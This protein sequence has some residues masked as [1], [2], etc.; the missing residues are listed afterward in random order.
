MTAQARSYSSGDGAKPKAPARYNKSVLHAGGF[1]DKAQAKLE[2]KKAYSYGFPAFYP[3][4]NDY[5]DIILKENA[6][7]AAIYMITNKVTKLKY[8][9]KSSNLQVRFVYFFSPG[10][11]EINKG[12][13]LISRYLL[14]FGFKNFSLT[15]L[16]Y[17]PIDDLQRR[18]QYFINIFKPLLNIRK[19]ISGGVAAHT[20][21]QSPASINLVAPKIWKKKSSPVGFHQPAEYSPTKSAESNA[22]SINQDGAAIINRLHYYNPDLAEFKKNIACPGG[23]QQAPIEVKDMMDL[24]ESNNNPLE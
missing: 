17:C 14:R 24:A 6:G 21:W 23:T 22:P 1:A 13:S 9:G 12:S 18:K 7:K 15:I 19:K 3:N 8:I 2:V 20:G 16:E 5:K 10:F 4:L 11:L